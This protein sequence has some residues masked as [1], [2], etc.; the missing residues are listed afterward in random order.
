MEAI[1][2]PR[3]PRLVADD[4]GPG[5]VGEAG[6]QQGRRH[7][8]GDLGSQ[9]RHQHL[10]AGDDPRQP[11]GKGGDPPQVADEHKEGHEGQQ[12][13]V[14]NPFQGDAVGGQGGDQHRSEGHP[15]GQHPHH[16]Q[17][18]HQEQHPV[19]HH[20]LLV[21]VGAVFGGQE[22]PRAGP[23]VAAGEHRPGGQHHQGGQAVGQHQQHKLPHPHAAFAVKVE[24]LGVADGGQHAA[25]VRRHR[26]HADHRQGQFFPAFPPPGC[27]A[28]QR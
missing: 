9:H 3:P 17:Q 11:V 26:L 28:P 21:G 23:Q 19:H 18:A 27:P 8:A 5:V 6:Q 14:V 20:N 2:V 16:R 4:E 1:R 24:V 12:Q 25:E 22:G 10:P 7:V 15:I 13:G